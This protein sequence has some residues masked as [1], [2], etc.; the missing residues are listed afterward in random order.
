[1]KHDKKSMSINEW[2]ILKEAF[3]ESDLVFRV[4]VIDYWGAS[5]N[6][7]AIINKDCVKIYENIKN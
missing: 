5:E 3:E 6:F 2:G 7:R 4:D 1:M